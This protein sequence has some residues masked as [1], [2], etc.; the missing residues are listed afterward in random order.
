[1]RIL[2]T[3][4]EQRVKELRARL[5]ALPDVTVDYTDGDEE[6]DY[7]AYDAIFDL[8]LDDDPTLLPRYASLKEKPVLVNAVKTTLAEMVYATDAKIKCR[9]FG[10]NALPGFLEHPLWEMSAYRRFEYPMLESMLQTLRLNYAPVA[11]R[12]G[13]V[14]PRVIFMIINEACYTLQEG[15]ASIEDIDQSMKLG[16]HYPYGPFE[17]CDKI[18]I[19]TVFETLTALYDDTHDERYRICPLLKHKYLRNETFY[20]SK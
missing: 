13:M 2:V 12:V 5:A 20:K 19:T 8:N 16:T 10:I 4:E 11:D 6:E 15:T 17:W 7:E 3:G 14:K 18:G 1:M 9:L